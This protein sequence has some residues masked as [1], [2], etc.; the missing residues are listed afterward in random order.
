MIDGLLE[1]WALVHGD[2]LGWVIFKA[3]VELIALFMR[4]GGHWS[5]RN[6]QSVE[7]RAAGGKA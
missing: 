5:C 7:E 1:F 3:V 6:A 2:I 4:D